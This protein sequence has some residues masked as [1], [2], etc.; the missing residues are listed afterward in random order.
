MTTFLSERTVKHARKE[1]YC[2]GCESIQSYT[3]FKDLARNVPMTFSEKRSLVEVK[4]RNYRIRKGDSH[5][6]QTI[7]FDGEL[8]CN[9]II[10]EI[11]ELAIKYK[12]YGEDE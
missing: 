8:Y 12:L 1:Y 2:S 10:P 3:D 7:V 6:R 5:I 9:K 11:H 4:N